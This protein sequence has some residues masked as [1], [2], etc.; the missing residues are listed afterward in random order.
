MPVYL[1]VQKRD[2]VEFYI[3]GKF[4]GNFD[5]MEEAMAD[6]NAD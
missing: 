1:F 2:Y 5:S 6:V 4:M 3:D